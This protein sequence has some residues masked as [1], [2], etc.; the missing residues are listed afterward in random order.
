MKPQ[1]TR[2]VLFFLEQVVFERSVFFCSRLFVAQCFFTAV[3]SLL[4]VFSQQNFGCSVFFYNR[5][6]GAQCMFSNTGGEDLSEAPKPRQMVAAIYFAVG[7]MAGA[8][9]ATV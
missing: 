5:I 9:Y 6:L 4:S 8:G 3:F 7:T 1:N 2:A